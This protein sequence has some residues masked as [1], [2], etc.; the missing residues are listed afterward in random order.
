MIMQDNPPD[1]MRMTYVL[2]RGAYD[3][4][5]KEEVIRPAVPK[6]LP[7][8]PDGAPANR[9]GLAQWLTQPSH[10][11]TARVA[12]NRYWMMLFGEGLVRSV[13]DFGRTKHTA[14]SSRITRLACRGLYGKR[15]GREAHA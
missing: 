8:L 14:N 9:L 11:L 15:M 4:P 3:S 10:P 13:G 5:K 12:V 1:K 2:D 7:P 6:A